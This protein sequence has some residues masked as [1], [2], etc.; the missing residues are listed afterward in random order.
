MSNPTNNARSDAANSL[1]SGKVPAAGSEGRD[2]NSRAAG[3]VP[4]TNGPFDPVTLFITFTTYGTWL[5]GD[6]RGWRKW[7]TGAQPSQPLL[8]NWCRERMQE[9]PLLL[10]EPHR[11]KVEAVIRDHA[12]I[13]GWLLHAVSVRSNHVHIAVTVDGSPKRARDQFKAN[14]TRVLRE[15]P[16]AIANDKIWTKG[17]DIQ[18]VDTDDGLHQVVIYITEAQDRMDRVH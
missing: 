15:P 18:F 6:R 8:E 17:G 4:L 13:R 2:L 16:H 10:S 11:K 14:A 12:K 1:V 5:P 3:S 7:K 9:Q